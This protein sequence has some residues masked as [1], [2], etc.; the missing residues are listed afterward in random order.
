M[1]P[2]KYQRFVFA[3]FMALFMSGF[4]SLVISVFNVGFVADIGVIW[5]KAW[6]FAF[7]VAFPTV[8][9]VAPIVQKITARLVN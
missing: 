9:F 8:I 3:F 2:A 7:V 5:L 1:I 6:S 4:M